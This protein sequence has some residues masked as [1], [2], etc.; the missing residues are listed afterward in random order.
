MD[1]NNCK[2]DFRAQKWA[3]QR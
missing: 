3:G 2:A 1:L